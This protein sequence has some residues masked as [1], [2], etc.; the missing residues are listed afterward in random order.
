M[1]IF[2]IYNSRSV[3]LMGCH[4]QTTQRESRELTKNQL[5]ETLENIY[6]ASIC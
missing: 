3:R 6:K 1:R 5:A 4:S 2:A